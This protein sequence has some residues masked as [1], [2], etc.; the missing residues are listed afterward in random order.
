VRIENAPEL[1]LR[2][3]PLRKETSAMVKLGQAK[4]QGSISIT[5]NLLLAIVTATLI[6][7]VIIV[8]LLL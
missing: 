1:E 8:K 5:G 3:V 4:A 2:G 6:A 7:A